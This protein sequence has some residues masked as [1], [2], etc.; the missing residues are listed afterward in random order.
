MK[1]PVLDEAI[2]TVQ[3]TGD[4]IVGNTE[5]AESRWSNYF[6][7]SAIGTAGALTV[8]AVGAA[9][10][11][12]VGNDSAERKCAKIASSSLQKLGAVSLSSVSEVGGIGLQTLT[13][14][15]PNPLSGAL[16]GFANGM[17]KAIDENAKQRGIKWE[18]FAKEGIIAGVKGGVSSGGIIPYVGTMSEQA[19]R[20]QR[21]KVHHKQELI[22]S[23]FNVGLTCLNA[24]AAAETA[25]SILGPKCPAAVADAVGFTSGASA[26]I[27]TEVVNCEAEM[28][29]IMKEGYA[30]YKDTKIDN[31]IEYEVF[32][33][34]GSPDTYVSKVYLGGETSSDIQS[35]CTQALSTYKKGK[36]EEQKKNAKA[37]ETHNKNGTPGTT[38]RNCKKPDERNDNVQAKNSVKNTLKTNF[39]KSSSHVIRRLR[40]NKKQHG[41]MMLINE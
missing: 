2:R 3:S 12:V 18:N 7:D 34:N 13:M 21:I 36:A 40:I 17:N 32:R 8:G 29:K 38:R 22:G 25:K 31:G 19:L 33:E 5:R 41:Y 10:A 1:I 26:N 35:P 23:V 30:Y 9:G 14:G 16:N 39:K 11:A 28:R 4:F 27:A 20:G 6:K 15:V 24:G 37:K